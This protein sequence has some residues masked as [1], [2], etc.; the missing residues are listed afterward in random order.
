MLRRMGDPTVIGPADLFAGGPPL[1][2]QFKLGL[3][4]PDDLRMARRALLFV[5]VAWV[6]LLVLAGLEGN[7]TLSGG[8]RGFLVDLGAMGRFLAAGPL[9]LAAEGACIGVLSS[10]ALRFVDLLREPQRDRTRF[11]STLADLKRLRDTPLAEVAV[12]LLAFGLS[13]A[14]IKGVP[15][16]S[17]PAWHLS[18]DHATRSLAGWWHAVVSLPLLLLLLLGWVWRLF[19]WSRFLVLASRLELNLVSVHPDKSA[20]LA[21]VGYSLRPFCFVGAALG[22][23]F[24]GTIANEVVHHGASI[25]SYQYVIGGLVAFVIALFTAPLLA[26]SPKLIRVWQQG[27]LQYGELATLFGRR[28]EREWFEGTRPRSHDD[29]L[30]RGDFSAGTDLFQVVDRVHALSIVP[31]DLTSIAILALATLLPF[32]PVVL[33]AVPFDAVLGALVGLVH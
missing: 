7:L 5:L 15:A 29:I 1:K 2:L 33:V 21:F 25:V 22:A 10:I 13:V 3:V 23:I 31:V 32:V 30:E 19:L 4:T 27:V 24:A 6:P 9:L 26:F 16:A 14:A 12:A 8:G 11:M 17:L 28:F 20:G 18:G